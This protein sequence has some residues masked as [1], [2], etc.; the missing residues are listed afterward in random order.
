MDRQFDIR[1]CI[2]TLA[3]NHVTYAP[4]ITT[5]FRSYG[6]IN[7]YK[8]HSY[9]ENILTK[10]DQIKTNPKVNKKVF[11]KKAKETKINVLKENSI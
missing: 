7:L 6:Q 10:I 4:K 5:K 11:Q 3:C 8:L 2:D 1:T 9:I